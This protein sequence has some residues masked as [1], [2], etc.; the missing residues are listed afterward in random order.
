MTKVFNMLVVL[1]CVVSLIMAITLFYADK[2]INRL[3]K[4]L[5]ELTVECNS[6]KID[7]ESVLET[8]GR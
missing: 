8:Y 4:E 6:L 5:D 7:Y 3:K 2:E 1:L